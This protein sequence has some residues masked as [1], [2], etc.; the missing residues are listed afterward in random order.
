MRYLYFYKKRIVI[1][2]I[3]VTATLIIN[4]FVGNK[5]TALSLT[6]GAVTLYYSYLKQNIEDEMFFEKL[7][8]DFNSRYNSQMN[9]LFN[10]LRIA[11]QQGSPDNSELKDSDKM[12]VIDY[13]NMCSEQYFWYTK[14]RILPEVWV[15]WEAGIIANLNLKS[16]KPI[17]T[18]EKEQCV[19]YYGFMEHIASRLP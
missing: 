17:F 19:S 14:K 2:A 3:I 6:I 16:V 15:A 7:F 1:L 8:K 5:V 10:K 13:L 9:D 18:E 12:I 11:E 4:H